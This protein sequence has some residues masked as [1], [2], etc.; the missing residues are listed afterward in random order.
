MILRGISDL[1]LIR[2]GESIRNISECKG[3]FY[4][5]DADRETVGVLQDRL[6]PLTEKG[7]QQAIAAGLGLKDNFGIPDTVIHSGFMRTQQTAKGILQAYSKDEFARIE[8][9][10]NH[11]IRERNPGCLMNWT[12]AEVNERLPWWNDYWRTADKFS[13]VP[14]GGESIAA[15]I[16]GRLMFFMKSLEKTSFKKGGNP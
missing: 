4:Q 9:E 16:E 8:I 3:S 10:E 5:N 13:V 15:M 12:E 1:V 6:I 2:H 11:L 7:R 14:F